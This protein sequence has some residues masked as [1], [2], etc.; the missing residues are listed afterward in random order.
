MI[1]IENLNKKFGRQQ[2][3]ARLSLQFPP[4]ETIAMIG[5]NGSGKTTLIKII[6]GLVIADTGQVKVKGKPVGRDGQY[7]SDIGYMP[8]ISR[9]PE[10]MRVH[11]LFDLIYK[12][13]PSLPESQYD[14]ELYQQFDIDTMQRKELG[15][16]SGGMQ[17][18]VNAALAFLFDPD[19]LILD[20]PTAALDP[21]ANELLKEKINRSREKG[22]LVLITSHILNDLDEVTTRVLYLMEGR[23]LFYKSLDELKQE[24]SESRLNKI[25]TQLL[26]REKSHV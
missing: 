8:Q 5:P 17:Q 10:H 1:E 26:N 22:K 15:E 2:V 6:L 24:T 21:L 23:Q 20:E 7:R 12:L 4:G 3:L 11:Q 16:L 13:R 19:I 9:F 18:K 14:R 25:I